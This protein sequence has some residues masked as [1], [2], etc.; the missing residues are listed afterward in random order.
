MG[1]LICRVELDKDKGVTVSVDSGD[2]K[3]LQ[4][5]VMNGK[6]IIV[7]CKGEKGTSTITQ[8]PESIAIACKKFS[9]DAEETITM[10]SKKAFTID[11]K[12]VL[13]AKSA[14]AMSLQTDAAFTAKSKAAA[15]LQGSAVTVKGSSAAA[16]L[17]GLRLRTSKQRMFRLM[18]VRRRK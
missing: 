9:V 7:T 1:T 13:S 10:N 11:S 4:T 18:A 15:T 6:Q 5:I 17:Q 2:G 12:D 8:D 3:M 14:K 16:T